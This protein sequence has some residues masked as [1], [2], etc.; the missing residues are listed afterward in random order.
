[1]DLAQNLT[2]LL[3]FAADAK[4]LI[5]RR[6]SDALVRS[7]MKHWPFKV[8]AGPGNKPMIVVQY[9]N[10]EKHFAAEEISSMVLMKMRDTAEAY[11][12][13]TV[14]SAVVTVPAYFN[15]SQRQATKDAGTIAG[16]NI[17]RLTNEPTAAAIAYGF[18]NIA[19]ARKRR[20]F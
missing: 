19:K 9:L 3:F 7:D 2:L 17:M 8:V 13:T 5:G 1:M 4:R 12:G 16:L 10:E 6:F 15:D 11:L 14:E 18:H 20:R